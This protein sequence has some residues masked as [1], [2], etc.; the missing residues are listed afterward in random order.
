MSSPTIAIV[1]ASSDPA[2]FGNK[3]VKAYLKQGYVVYPVNPKGGEIEGMPFLA[4]LAHVP[5]EHLDR[6]SFYLPPAVG[7]KVLEEAADKPHGELWLN[8][9]S[10]SDELIA[11]AQDLGLDPIVACSIVDVGIRPD[12][13]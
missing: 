1:G 12:E 7:M 10:E 9:G 3:A 5:S 11:R 2:K 6:I 4:R 8:P 13:V